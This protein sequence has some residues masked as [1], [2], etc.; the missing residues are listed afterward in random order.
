MQG[1]LTGTDGWFQGQNIKN[2]IYSSSHEGIGKNGEVHIYVN[3]D[4]TA[5]HAGRIN[6]PIWAGIKKAIWGSYINPNY[7]TYGIENE[8]FRGETWAEEQM[9][10]LCQRVKEITTKYN[11]PVTRANIISHHEITADKENMSAWCDEIV[12]RLTQQTPPSSA[13]N[14]EE[15]KKQIKDLVDKL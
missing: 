13:V 7:Y 8:G 9:K 14:K 4:D 15:T 3:P 1:S 11:I 2:G 10:S 6:Q 5:Y 12:K